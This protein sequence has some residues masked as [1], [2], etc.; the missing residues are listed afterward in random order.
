[1]MKR[2]RE[3]IQAL[4]QRM[5]RVPKSPTY[6]ILP[7]SVQLQSVIT[8]VLM[9]QMAESSQ[10]SQVSLAMTSQPSVYSAHTRPTRPVSGP[11]YYCVACIAGCLYPTTQM[12][13]LYTP[14][15]DQ[16]LPRA[17]LLLPT[18]CKPPSIPSHLISPN[19]TVP[20][21]Y[22]NPSPVAGHTTTR[23]F[24]RGGAL[25][26]PYVGCSHAENNQ[27]ASTQSKAKSTT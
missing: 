23:T 17:I 11:Q 26:P 8:V 9:R 2:G 24:T 5:R 1:M 18:L 6:L 25:P 4:P 20:T 27:Q 3:C 7:A 19:T 14:S 13:L 22:C 16:P 21:M 15:L 12:I 10:S